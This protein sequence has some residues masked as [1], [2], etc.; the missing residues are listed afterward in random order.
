MWDSHVGYLLAAERMAELRAEADAARRAAAMRGR[1]RR[2]SWR[3]VIALHT[4]RAGH[5]LLARSTGAR[6]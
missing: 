6:A 3:K 2:G 5:G 4:G 1:R